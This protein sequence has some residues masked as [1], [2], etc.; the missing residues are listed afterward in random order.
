MRARFIERSQRRIQRFHRGLN[1]A[2]RLRRSPFQPADH[3]GKR[4]HARTRSGDHIVRVAQILG[5]LFGLHHRRTPFGKRRFL[6]G[7]RRELVELGDRVAQ[8]IT[9]AF[10]AL[11]LGP[12]R[13]GRGLRVAPGGPKP[14]DLRRSIFK[15]AK[16]IEQPAMRC[17]IHQCPL[18]VLAVDFDKGAPEL[19]EHLHAHRLVIDERAGAAVGKLHAAKNKLILSGNIVG[20]QLRP[21]RVIARHIENGRHLP[22]AQAPGAPGSDRPRPPNASA[23]ASSKMDFP[24]PVSPVSTARPSAKSMSRRSIRTMSRMESRESMAFCRVLASVMP[25]LVP[26]IHVLTNST[27]SKT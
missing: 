26:G 20:S 5:Y 25:G 6:A 27:S 11:N 19:L 15:P 8:P 3:A 14:F 12:M 13:I 16:S 21:H 22:P 18:V 9:L 4:R 10:C 23:K 2:R 7:L 24:A 1:Q 17:G